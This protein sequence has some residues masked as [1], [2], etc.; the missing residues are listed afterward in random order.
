MPVIKPD[1]S[2]IERKC[3]AKNCGE[4][5]VRGYKLC[6]IHKATFEYCK[7]CAIRNGAAD[8]THLKSILRD[9]SLLGDHLDRIINKVSRIVNNDPEL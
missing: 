4:T 2:I 1:K 3:F 9:G 8:V 7:Y 5:A 6:E